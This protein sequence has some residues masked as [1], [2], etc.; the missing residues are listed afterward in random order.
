MRLAVALNVSVT[1]VGY[2]WTGRVIPE[3]DRSPE[4]ATVTGYSVDAVDRILA[5]ARRERARRRG[6]RRP[7]GGFEGLPPLAMVE[8]RPITRTP[9]RPRARRRRSASR[10]A[11]QRSSDNLA[12]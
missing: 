8:A 12:A 4:L 2:W 9:T 11:G 1:T 10:A 5:E 6:P 7:G 3:F